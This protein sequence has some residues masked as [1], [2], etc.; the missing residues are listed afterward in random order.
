MTSFLEWRGPPIVDVC[1]VRADFGHLLVLTAD[2]VL[3]G[4]DVDA[5]SIA[6]LC[7]VEL[8]D[9][10]PGDTN[11]FFGVAAHR[12]HATSDGR[13]AAIVVDKG[14][15]GVVVETRSGAVTMHLDGGDYHEDTVPFSA[16]FLR[17]GGRDAFVHRTAWNRLDV[18]DPATGESLTPRHIAPYETAGKAP[19]HYLDYFHGQLRPS[20]EGGLLF[21]DGWVWHP[22]SVPRVWSVTRW[23]SANPWESE[24]GPSIVD[25]VA[26][27][28]WTKPACWIDERRLALWGLADWDACEFAEAGQGPGVR[29]VD[30]TA[31]E[32]S[33][34]ELWPMESRTEKV[35]DLFS[36]GVCLFVATEAGTTVWDIATRALVTEW[37]G[38]TARL[39]DRARS[40]LVAF[41]PDRIREIPIP[42]P[43][44]AGGRL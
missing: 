43:V 41:G 37:Q 29:I 34:N 3:H 39:F 19:E 10:V 1:V 22:L 13:H 36:D 14:R 23:L 40:T 15:L 2:G 26:A 12:L 21:D 25:L 28:D 20:P 30:V 31:A 11:S 18:A 32:P 33:A 7:S 6:R 35:L 16:C 9:L 24:D 4:V 44:A 27:E 8:P 17:F 42:G 38:F 5:R